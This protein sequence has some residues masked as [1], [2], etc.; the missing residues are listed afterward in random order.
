MLEIHKKRLFMLADKLDTMQVIFPSTI[1]IGYKDDAGKVEERI[2]V[3]Y[4]QD[5]PVVGNLFPGK[6]IKSKWGT[7]VLVSDPDSGPLASMLEFFG[8]EFWFYAHCFVPYLQNVELFGG[9]PLSDAG[10]GVTP[11]CIAYNIREMV[12]RM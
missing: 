8:L 2:F 11:Q 4:G 7:L 9:K 12:K 6:W 5:M 10:A 1:T 3:D